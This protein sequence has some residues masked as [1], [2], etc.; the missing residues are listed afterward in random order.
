MSLKE[1][2]FRDKYIKENGALPKTQLLT[3]YNSTSIP[4]TDGSAF[5]GVKEYIDSSIGSI[6]INLIADQPGLLTSYQSLDNG[7]TFDIEETYSILADTPLSI[8]IK[9]M[10]SHFKI[11]ILNNSGYDQTKLICKTEFK[12]TGHSIFVDGGFVNIFST[13]LDELSFTGND[14]NVH[15][16]NTVPISNL[17]LDNLS[18]TDTDKLNVNVTNSSLAVTNSALSTMSFTGSELNVRFSNA[19]LPVTNASLSAMTFTGSDLNV[20]FSNTTL[21]VTNSALSTMSF[22]STNLNTNI[23]NSSLAVTNTNLSSL[24]FTGSD[25]NVK[26]SNTTLPVTG[27]VAIS[28]AVTTSSP[29]CTCVR[30]QYAIGETT[31]TPAVSSVTIKGFTFLNLSNLTGYLKFYDINSPGSLIPSDTALLMYKVDGGDSLNVTFPG[32]LTFSAGLT[33]RWTQYIGANSAGTLAQND[34]TPMDQ[35]AFLSIFYS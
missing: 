27:T 1:F 9:P 25:L 2:T 22:T 33:V 31:K 34:V 28:G 3:Y 13:V 30:Y 23:T 7:K 5:Y 29:T 32:N 35:Q 6:H 21:P 15:V 11:K 12:T 19:S 20:K 10:G 18:F 24:T 14:L 4:L 8:Q 26:F 17:N 16:K